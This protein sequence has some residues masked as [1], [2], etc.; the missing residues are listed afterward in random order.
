MES[1]LALVHIFFSKRH[2]LRHERG[3]LYGLVDLFANVGG[4]LGLCAGFSVLNFVE[5]IYSY[6][7]RYFF[8]IR[9]G[10]KEVIRE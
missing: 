2:F 10:R 8:N 6:T 7:L 9:D 4:L 1:N 5:G 3:E